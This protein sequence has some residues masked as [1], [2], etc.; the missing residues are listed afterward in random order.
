MADTFRMPPPP[1]S[2]YNSPSGCRYQENDCKRPHVLYCTNQLCV[3]A[4][5]YMTHAFRDCGRPGGAAHSQYIAAK[6]PSLLGPAFTPVSVPVAPEPT[7]ME[8]MKRQ[9]CDLIYK[10][11]EALLIE[12]KF[13]IAERMLFV[14]TPGKVTGMFAEALTLSDLFRLLEDDDFFTTQVADAFDVLYTNFIKTGAM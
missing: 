2:F 10:K 14:P 4:N 9:A 8:L 11:I 5:R 7:A 6:A 3:S 13:D 1:C 12:T